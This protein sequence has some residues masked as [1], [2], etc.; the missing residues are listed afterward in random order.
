MTCTVTAT[1]IEGAKQ[2]VDNAIDYGALRRLG[3]DVI[4]DAVE[5][6]QQEDGK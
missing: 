3:I 4:A 5:I 6:I 1:T 2:A